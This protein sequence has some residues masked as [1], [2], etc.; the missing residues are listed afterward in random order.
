[1]IEMK[2]FSFRYREGAKSV[3]EGVSLSI[4]DGAFVG[5]TGSAGSGKSTLTYAMNG[6]IPH[7]YPGD[8]FGSVTVDGLDTCETSLTDISRIVASGSAPFQISVKA[9]SRRIQKLL[10]S[11][12]FGIGTESQYTS[13]K[14]SGPGSV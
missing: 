12:I 14:A 6:I 5:I 1:M 4:P 13:K 11:I 10:V 2:D 8:F 3:V 9:I 7:C